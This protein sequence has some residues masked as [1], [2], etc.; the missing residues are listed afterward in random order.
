M[1]WNYSECGHRKGAP[2]GI[3]GALKRMANRLEAEDTNLHMFHVLFDVLKENSS[4]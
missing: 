4:I 3:G 1:T 2:D